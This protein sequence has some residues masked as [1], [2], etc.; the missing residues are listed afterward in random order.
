MS[1]QNHSINLDKDGAPTGFNRDTDSLGTT[2]QPVVV[3]IPQGTYV[4]QS[5]LQLYVGTVLMGD[6]INL[7]IIKAGWVCSSCLDSQVDADHHRPNFKGDTLIYGK[8]PHHD[9]TTN[10]YIGI[11]NIQLDSTNLSSSTKFTILDWSVSQAT[12]L[13]NIV[14]NMPNYSTGH[15]GIAMP[16]GGSGCSMG[17]LTFNGGVV[18]LNMGSQQYEVKSASFNRCTTGIF[19]S[20]CF[21][22]VLVNIEFES[23]AVGIDMSQDGGHSV[24][25]IDSVASNTGTAVEAVACLTGDHTLV[26]ENFVSGPGLKAVVSVSGRSILSGSVLDTWVYGNVYAPGG[27]TTGAHKAGKMYRTVRSSSL[28]CTNKYVTIPP[29]TYQEYNLDQFVNVKQVDG[30]S[31]RGDGESDDTINLNAIISCYAGSKILFFPQGTY[32]VTDTL[33]FPPGSRV[34]GEAWSAISAFGPKFLNPL[35]PKPMIKVGN[36]GDVGVSHFLD[37]LFTVADVLPGCTLAEVN[38]AGNSPGD[39]AFWNSHFRIGGTSQFA[40]IVSN[41]LTFDLNRRSRLESPNE[42]RR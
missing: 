5:S 9:S 33:F 22:C 37:M 25:L 27:P 12:Q 31:V 42:L 36:P 6:P 17:D 13:T 28:L 26:I 2:G 35:A 16:E 7:P 29:P 32:I 23:N 18:G 4:L 3:Y 14:F 39:V 30:F 24:T 41:L 15:T 10:F 20:G 34:I 1:D 21:A 19:I 11:K 40:Q 38:M 8:D